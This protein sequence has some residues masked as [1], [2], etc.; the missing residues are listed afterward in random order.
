MKIPLLDE[1]E[2]SLEFVDAAGEPVGSIDLLEAQIILEECI[3]TDADPEGRAWF[4]RFAERLT[5]ILGRHVSP[6]MAMLIGGKISDK[7]QE[8][9]KT[10][11][12]MSASLS[13]TG[14]ILSR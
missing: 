5:E 14:S 6:S 12:S 13:S 8:L 3:R 4:V 7:F 10:F 11:E 9:K 2:T 1:V